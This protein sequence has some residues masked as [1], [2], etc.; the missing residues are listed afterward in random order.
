MTLKKIRTLVVDDSAVIREIICDVFADTSDIEVV[1]TAKDGKDAL[2]QIPSLQP[3]VVTLDVQMPHLDGLQTLDAILKKDPIPVVMVSALTQRAADTTL[4]ALDQGALDY[5][6]KPDGVNEAR[7]TFQ[8]ELV[9]KVR[10]ASGT[11]VRRVL[12]IRNERQ[13]RI[14]ARRSKRQSSIAEKS[15]TSVH[16]KDK[17]LAIGISTGGPPALTQLFSSLQPPMPPIVVVQHMPGQFTGPFSGRLD[18]VSELSIKEAE[19]GDVL[20]PDHVLIAPGGKH[21]H[22]E[23]RGSTVRA[24][25]RDGENVSGHKPSVDVMMSC[26]AEIFGDRCLGVIMTGMGR[27]GADGCGRIREN[28]GYVLGQDQ[29]T[30]DVYG[31]NKVAY[32]EGHVDR[33]FALEDGPEL[34]RSQMDRLWKNNVSELA[35]R[36]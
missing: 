7:K 17:I 18:S 31:M 15:Q 35:T 34:L 2:N 19:T 6:A 36:S 29:A 11:D 21:L 3:D 32:L 14:D 16:L 8:E 28:G 1:G 13:Q 30:S 12:Q 5:V 4:A 10:S 20:R 26:A 33:Q 23:K 22:L 27:D 24:A 25:V 9:R